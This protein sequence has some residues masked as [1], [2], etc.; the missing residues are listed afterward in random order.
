MKSNPTSP[1]CLRE[2]LLRDVLGRIV[3]VDQATFQIMLKNVQTYVDVIFHHG[4]SI[5]LMLCKCQRC[6]FGLYIDLLPVVGQQMTQISRRIS[7]WAPDVVDPAPLILIFATLIQQNKANSR[8][9]ETSSISRA[10]TQPL[11]GDDFF[12][13][14]G[15]ASAAQQI[16][17][18]H[19]ES[20]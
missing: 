12:Y 19:R 7:E 20:I 11:V 4:Y 10:Y 16:E 1:Q 17:R 5:D 2:L 8:V 13:R 18:Q 15:C 9:S 6:W 14:Y 3:E